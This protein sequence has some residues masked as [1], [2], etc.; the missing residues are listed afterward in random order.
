VDSSRHGALPR[1]N[2]V[3][4]VNS[5][6]KQEGNAEVNQ[7][8]NAPSHTYNN[9]QEG[10]TAINPD[11]NAPTNNTDETIATSTEANTLAL[12]HSLS[13]PGGTDTY[14]FDSDSERICIDTG[15]SACISAVKEN[16][17]D[18]KHMNNVKIN[19]IA[20]GLQVEGIGLLK[21]HIRD[22]DNKEIELYIKDA[23]YVPKAPMGLLCPKQIAQQT[24][25]PG[26]GFKALRNHGI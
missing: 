11:A 23:L 9:K 5:N 17:I 22:D 4:T 15:A 18:M 3:V 25:K 7:D 10:K 24:R 8:A 6:H 12:L 21:W 19:G 16:F 2:N 14:N 26:D 1:T 13:T 20:S